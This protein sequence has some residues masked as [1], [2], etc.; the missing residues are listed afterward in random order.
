MALTL[1]DSTEQAKIETASTPTGG[2][3]KGD[4]IVTGTVLGFAATTATLSQTAA[5]SERDYSTLY[6]LVTK[7]RT[8]LCDKAAG[9]TIAQNAAVYVDASDS[10]AKSGTT[11]NYKVGYATKAAASADTTVEIEFDGT[12]HA[13]T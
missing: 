3:T 5:N 2:V 6:G 12:L 10:T 13:L 11:G 8:V 4:L 1:Q 9:F 7:A